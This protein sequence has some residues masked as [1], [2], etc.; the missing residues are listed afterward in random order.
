MIRNTFSNFVKMKTGFRFIITVLTVVCIYAYPQD[1][2]ATSVSKNDTVFTLRFQGNPVRIIINYPEQTV[3]GNL[4]LLHGWNLPANEWCEKTTLCQ[5]ALD[6]GFVLIIP[7]FGKTTYHYQQYPETIFKYRKY[8]TRKWMYDTA[9]VHLQNTFGLLVK[10]ENNFVAGLSTGGRGAALFALEHPEIFKACAALSADFDQTKI[11]DEPI[12]N[13][14]YGSYKKFPN[15]W[16]G[17][18]NIYNSAS[19]WQVPL[20]LAHGESDSICPY[21]Q[22]AE[23][24]YRLKTGYPQLNVVFFHEKKAGHTYS[25]WEKSTDK[26][27]S[28]FMSYTK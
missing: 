16:E 22:S 15:R 6:S 4:L 28:F 7:D 27:I 24:Y 2:F 9:F 3:K 19:E 18:E 10:G 12:N 1:L 23:F 21:Q 25:F 8:P 26:I 5:K 11:S 20:F 13:G 14:Y 17:R